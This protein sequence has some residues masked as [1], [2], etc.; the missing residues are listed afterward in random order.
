MPTWVKVVLAVVATG[1]LGLA[2]LVGGVYWWVTSNKDRLKDEGKAALEGGRTYGAAHA[3]GECV[4]EAVARVSQ[5]G[6]AGFVCEATTKIWLKECLGKST[7]GPPSW[8]AGAPEPDSIVAGATWSADEC[9]RR[10]H[11]T[12]AC[13]R[14]MADALHACR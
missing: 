3:K 7:S 11:P 10:N 5:C 8:C 4:D 1:I 13:G 12:Q 2:V 9:R 14:L 6:V